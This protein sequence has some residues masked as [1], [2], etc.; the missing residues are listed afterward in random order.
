[1]RPGR[2]DRILYVGPP[3]LDSRREI[4]RIQ[5]KKMSCDEDVDIEEIAQ[6][7]S[8]NVVISIT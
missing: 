8:L 5:L 1:M 4:F 7:V 6:R 2:I 3:N